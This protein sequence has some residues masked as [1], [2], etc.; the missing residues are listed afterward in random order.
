[1]IIKC[2]YCGNIIEA[3]PMGPRMAN[4]NSQEGPME[5]PT[6]GGKDE[7]VAFECPRCGA[8]SSD[9]SVSSL[10]VVES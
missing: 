6:D 2:P 10:T 3:Q 9:A 1:M 7:T 8:E 4:W 5:V